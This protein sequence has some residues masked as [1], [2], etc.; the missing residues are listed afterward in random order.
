[1]LEYKRLFI[2]ADETLSSRITDFF[3]VPTKF[4]NK[5]YTNLGYCY[6]TQNEFITMMKRHETTNLY[7][8]DYFFIDYAYVKEYPDL[9][10]VLIME[11]VRPVV[12]IYNNI[13]ECSS[14]HEGISFNICMNTFDKD[15]SDCVNFLDALDTNH[16]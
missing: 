8:A 15:L 10:H 11:Y 3:L 5:K 16:S 6:N 2:F 4:C 13:K 7:L 1:M 14:K 9:L 12:C